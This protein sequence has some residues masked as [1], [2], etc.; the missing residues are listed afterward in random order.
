MERFKFK[1]V[2]MVGQF[3]LLCPPIEA[4]SELGAGQCC[5]PDFRPGKLSGGS[6]GHDVTD[7]V[8]LSDKEGK[9]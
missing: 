6:Q 2:F 9:H 5:C 4:S 7:C 3:G 1:K 8:L